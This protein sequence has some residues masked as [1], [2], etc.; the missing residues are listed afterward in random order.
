M[1]TGALMVAAASVM[2]AVFGRLDNRLTVVLSL[3]G[4]G[5]VVLAS[6]MALRRPTTRAVGSVLLALALA[7]AARLSSWELASQATET[8]SV[9]SYAMARVASTVGLLFEAGRRRSSL[10]S[11]SGDARAVLVRWAGRAGSVASVLAVA[12]LA[13]GASYA[14]MRGGR[15]DAPLLDVVLHT[16][17]DRATTPPAYFVGVGLT[18]FL[19]ATTLALAGAA[20]AAIPT[21]GAPAACLALALVSGGAFDVPLRSLA[22]VASGCFLVLALASRPVPPGLRKPAPRGDDD[23]AAGRAAAAQ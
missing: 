14:A 8:A 3:A 22:A 18:I 6:A 1:L 13:L 7:S 15:D 5:A 11:G 20:L 21:A 4:E 16:A 19:G 12:G 9:T 2:A 23:A 10:S 17:L